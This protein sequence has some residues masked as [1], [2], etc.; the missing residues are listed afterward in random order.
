M[1]CQSNA[2][3]IWLIELASK[4]YIDIE[5]RL[6]V[7]FGFLVNKKASFHREGI[8]NIIV[9]IPELFLNNFLEIRVLFWNNRTDWPSWL[10]LVMEIQKYWKVSNFKELMSKFLFSFLHH[11]PLPFTVSS[12]SDQLL[13]EDTKSKLAW[14]W[15]T[16]W[17]LVPHIDVS[18]SNL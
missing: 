16:V 14:V 5:F 13:Q 8:K 6:F 1:N 2:F 3:T 15:R 17:V 12:V 4:D 11:Y 18:D 7:S 9:W 10:V